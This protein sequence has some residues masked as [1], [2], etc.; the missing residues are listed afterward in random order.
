M[1]Q[2]ALRKYA[3]F[4]AIQ[5]S[6]PA[7][8]PELL[9]MALKDEEVDSLGDENDDLKTKIAEVMKPSLNPSFSPFPFLFLLPFFGFYFMTCNSL[10]C[11]FILSFFI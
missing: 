3:R 9:I 2:Q 8:L 5:L 6:D 1:Y 11:G 10:Q 7:P 4:N